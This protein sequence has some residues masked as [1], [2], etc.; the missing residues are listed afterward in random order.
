MRL[1]PESPVPLYHQIAEALR[2][3]IATGR[4]PQGSH[5]PPLREAAASWGVNLHTVRHAYGALAADGL[6]ERR[7][8]GGTVISGAPPRPRSSLASFLNDVVRRARDTHG[9][10]PDDLA[11]LLAD[12]SGAAPAPVVHFV[13]CSEIQAEG[14]CREI[15]GTWEV[16]ARPW[17][18][19]AGEP[20][21]GAVIST[22][23]HYNDLRRAWPERL[24]EVVFVTIRPDPGVS[25]SLARAVPKGGRTVTL[26]EQDE[27]AAKNIAADVIPF[28]PD[29]RLRIVPRVV[30]KPG[31]LL[32]RGRGAVLFS[33][34]VWSGLTAQERA[35]PRAVEVRYAIAP[36]DLMALGHP[37][38]WSRRGSA[39]NRAHAMRPGAS[40]PGK[41]P[42]P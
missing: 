34:R 40:L 17:L 36:G 1:D 38:H 10:G 14:H 19:G 21:A 29:P 41:G 31:A 24:G 32:R 18:L 2:Y 7:G 35:N 23:F 37:F 9:L 15:E 6:V 30:R 20:P 33:P 4:I 28:L 5:L 3:Q 11:R 39:G 25:V 42:L 22:Y 26:C 13:E 16:E 8:R 27:E 12:W